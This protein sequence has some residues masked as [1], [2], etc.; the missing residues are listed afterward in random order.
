MEPSCANLIILIFFHCTTRFENQLLM[1]LITLGELL[2]GNTQLQAICMDPIDLIYIYRGMLFVAEQ[3]LCLRVSDWKCDIHFE[4]T[5]WRCIR[6][7]LER[8]QFSGHATDWFK[9]GHNFQL[10][11]FKVC[12]I[13]TTKEH[14]VKYNNKQVSIV[15]HRW[16]LWGE[17]GNFS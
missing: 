4:G 6:I 7:C 9:D 5:F 3:T 11:A 16:I 15:C 13:N 14:D 17:S 12:R 10:L 2:D 1:F 8:E